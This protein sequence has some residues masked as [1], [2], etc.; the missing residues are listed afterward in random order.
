VTIWV[1]VLFVVAVALSLPAIGS[2]I[3]LAR[4]GPVFRVSEAAND[5]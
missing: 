4:S 5:E 2:A 3:Q 1:S